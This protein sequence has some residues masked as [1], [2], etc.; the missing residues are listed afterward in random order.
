MGAIETLF[1]ERGWQDAAYSGGGYP[2][3][4][5]GKDGLGLLIRPDEDSRF[6]TVLAGDPIS[7]ALIRITSFEAAVV[8]IDFCDRITPLVDWRKAS[9]WADDGA[10]ADARELSEKVHAIA[11]EVSTPDPHAT[12]RELR[13][14][15]ATLLARADELS[16]RFNALMR[17]AEAR[18]RNA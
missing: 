8:A 2:F 17:S 1:E 6:W 13:R 11:V 12:P 4:A 3:Y 14:R 18:Q 9:G 5:W 16:L 15:P 7:G 10:P